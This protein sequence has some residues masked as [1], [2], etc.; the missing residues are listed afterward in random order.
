[1]KIENDLKEPEVKICVIIATRN[2]AEMLSKLL[3]SIVDNQVKPDLISIVSSGVEIESTIVKFK[4]KLKIEHIHTNKSGQVLQRNLALENIKEIYDAYSFLDDDVILDQEF[5]SKI[6]SFL[7]KSDDS[8]GGVGVNLEREENVLMQNV[9]ANRICKYLNSNHISGKVLRSGRGIKYIG[10][11][12]I[13]Q[14]A[15][16]NGLSV[17]THPVISNF[18]HVPMGNRYAAA[19]DLIFSYKVG[20]VYKLYYNP[21]I[22]AKDQNS[23]KTNPPNLD[24][25]RTSWQHRLYFVL[26]NRELN[27]W[28]YILDNIFSLITLLISIIRGNIKVK[29]NIII[30]NVR[31]LYLILKNYRQYRDD[32]EHQLRLLLEIL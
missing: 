10:N 8:I 7:A 18:K 15:W 32:T 11:E 1:M 26:T 27:F 20:K 23:E 5:F 2:R 13:K 22:K 30:Y 31:F 4:D 19:E 25:Y 17:W 24:I 21:E 9:I 6:G 14:V 29:F 3:E 12:S 16:L 28:L